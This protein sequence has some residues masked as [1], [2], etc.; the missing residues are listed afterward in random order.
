MGGIRVKRDIGEDA[1]LVAMRLLDRTNGAAHE[2]IGIRRLGTIL[3]APVSLRIWEQCDTGYT[4]FD[5]FGSTHD[6]LVNGPARNARK[7]RNRIFNGLSFGH[8]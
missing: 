5:G 2:V 7:C 8:K 4:Q 6:N 1:D 3:A